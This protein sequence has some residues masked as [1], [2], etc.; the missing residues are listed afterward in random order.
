MTVRFYLLLVW[1]CLYAIMAKAGEI[2]SAPIRPG[3]RPVMQPDLS[4][5]H[6]FK[7]TVLGN[8]TKYPYSIPPSTWLNAPAFTCITEDTV[9]I[10]GREIHFSTVFRSKTHEENDREASVVERVQSTNRSPT[11]SNFGG[12][13]LVRH[14]RL[15]EQEHVT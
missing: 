5:L 13:V 11:F 10:L 15:V 12:H 4:N 9:E 1:L 14:L 6:S 2:G 3:M 8:K 7:E